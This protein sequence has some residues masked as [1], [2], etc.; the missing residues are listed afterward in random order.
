MTE[1]TPY[2]TDLTDAEWA[3]I[4][5]SV[6]PKAGQSGPKRRYS[7]REIV[8]ALLYQAKT[9]CHWRLLPHD[10][11]KWNLVRYY[12]DTWTWDHTIEELNDLLV[13]RVRVLE[14]RNAEP[15]AGSIDSQSVKTTEAGGDRG[16]D[17]GKKGG[18]SQA[19]YRGRF[20]GPPAAR[21]GARRR[22]A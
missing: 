2:E 19:P 16:F 14:G 4:A 15:S 8:N 11:P 9:G 1:R 21:E 20:P 12:F 7:T 6:L 10:F 3:E 22:C 17:G 5:P 18:R 13:R